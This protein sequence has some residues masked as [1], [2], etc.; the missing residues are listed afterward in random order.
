[1]AHEVTI[2]PLARSDLFDLY[3]YIEERSGPIRAGSYIDR[4]KALLDRLS[5]FPERGTPRTDLGA[6]VR[7][8]SLERR[9]LIVYRP[10]ADQV[11]ILRVIY[12]GLNFD[13]DDIPR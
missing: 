2:H 8:I 7:T 6:G 11:V 3:A 1:M 12:A 5:D 4:I 13:A 9:V 10:S